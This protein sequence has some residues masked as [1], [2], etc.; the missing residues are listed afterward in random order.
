MAKSLI[1]GMQGRQATRRH[2]LKIAGALAAGCT[3]PAVAVRPAAATLADMQ[4]AVRR[5]TGG[6]ALNVGKVKL[7]IPPL[8]ENG[9][10]V[11][12]AVSVE[13]PMTAADHVKAIHIFNEKNPQPNVISFRLGAR[14]GRASVSTR[15]RLSDSQTVLAIAELSDGSFWSDR[16]DVIITLGACLENLI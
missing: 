8:V 7:D 6:A 1:S 10:T 13:S 12:C 14:A 9:N 3:V 11:P 5:V 16:V 2:V 15:I 4:D